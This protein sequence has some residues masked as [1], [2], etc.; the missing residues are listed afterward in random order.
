M[1]SHK[2]KINEET[3]SRGQGHELESILNYED[4]PMSNSVAPFVSSGAGAHFIT[5]FLN[6]SRA[7]A[8]VETVNTVN[9]DEF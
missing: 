9:Q 7:G 6:P 8:A 2:G 5:S 1:P 4:L 3:K